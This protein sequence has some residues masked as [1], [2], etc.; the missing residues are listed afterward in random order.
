MCEGSQGEP[1]E[2]VWSVEL[3]TNLSLPSLPPAAAI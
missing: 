1:A 2:H 3:L